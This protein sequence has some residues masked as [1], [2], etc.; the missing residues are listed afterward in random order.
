MHLPPKYLSWP[1]ESF[2]LLFNSSPFPLIT[3]FSSSLTVLPTLVWLFLKI[4][5]QDVKYACWDV[6]AHIK[7]IHYVENI[8]P[9]LFFVGEFWGVGESVFFDLRHV[10]EIWV[11]HSGKLQTQ[12]HF[13]IWGEKICK[14]F[15]FRQDNLYGNQ[16]HKSAWKAR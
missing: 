2:R 11:Y 8:Y 9:F 4:S 6:W 16:S 3:G 7:N 13:W 10:S 5:E 15:W 1:R 14:G 12:S